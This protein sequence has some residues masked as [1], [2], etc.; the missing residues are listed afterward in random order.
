VNEVEHVSRGPASDE[1][2]GASSAHGIVAD[3]PPPWPAKVV[4]L[5]PVACGSRLWRLGG[6]ARLTVAVKA[7]FAIAHGAVARL[8]DPEPLLRDEPGAGE[9]GLSITADLAPRRPRADVVVLG[10]ASA[11]FGR[12]VGAMAVGVALLSGG[13]DAWLVDKT[14][15]VVGDRAAVDD[16]APRPFVRMPV[17]FERASL[18]ES[19]ARPPH[20][21]DPAH[22]GRAAGLGPLPRSWPTGA[23]DFEAP[24]LDLPAG[25]DFA[26]FQDAPEDQRV[27]AL[28]GDEWLVLT[29]LDPERPQLFTRL[30]GARALVRRYRAAPDGVE[31]GRPIELTADQLVVD[32]DRARL[33]LVWRGELALE[34]GEPLAY[35]RLFAGLEVP[36]D[37]V[38]WPDPEDIVQPGRPAPSVPTV[39]VALPGTAP[40]AI[41]APAIAPPAP[42]VAPP[43]GVSR[44]PTYERGLVDEATSDAGAFDPAEDVVPFHETAVGQATPFHEEATAPGRV[45]EGI[46]VERTRW[47][48][49][50]ALV[51][52]LRA[53]PFAAGAPATPAAR[54]GAPIPGAPWSGGPAASASAFTPDEI[55]R[56]HS[57][58]ELL[59][60]EAS[61]DV[62]ASATPAAPVAGAAPTAPI[63]PPPLVEPSASS[64]PSSSADEPVETGKSSEVERAPDGVEA[65]ADGPRSAP[66]AATLEAS[67]APPSKERLLARLRAR[68]PVDDRELAEAD[69]SDVDFNGCSLAGRS[70]REATL[71]RS[72]FGG[73]VVAGVDFSGADL[74]DAD[75]AGADLTRAV[76][77]RAR[78]E[79]ASLRGAD[80]RQARLVEA[81]LDGA[82]LRE[83]VAGKIDLTRASL[84][85]AD[86]RGAS[87]RAARMKGAVLARAQVDGADLRDADLEGASLAGCALD[88]AKTVGANLRNTT[89]DG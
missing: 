3:V 54:P 89:S 14:L 80:L 26:C 49:S 47:L 7:T 28:R 27:D 2:C 48:S 23:A 81:R 30:P 75:F 32:A 55:T 71:R 65:E 70:L 10:H 22:P 78:L 88:R 52:D 25:L 42:A 15:L 31:A 66:R 18:R 29:G 6:T 60:R 59:G 9:A 33:S 35:V 82:D 5:S 57:L 34:P 76:F 17:S 40:P 43:P 77:A 39:A 21:I 86:L 72:R 73:A 64:S 37:T 74:G 44:A 56:E 16:L 87:L 84:A 58:R 41:V 53:V 79:G 45:L 62:P 51:G 67:P 50:T 11:P 4:A 19:S 85:G 83:I 38:T 36:G 12:P 61:L 24:V 63:E 69:L 1:V 8:V 13:R 46:P 20:V 68:E